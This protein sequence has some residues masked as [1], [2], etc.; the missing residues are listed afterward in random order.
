MG[1]GGGLDIGRGGGAVA[2]SSGKT[3]LGGGE[4]G[5]CCSG[6]GAVSSVDSVFFAGK[7]TAFDVFCWSKGEFLAAA[8]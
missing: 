3:V 8:A 4:G 2:G 7:F 5:L 6:G 1:S